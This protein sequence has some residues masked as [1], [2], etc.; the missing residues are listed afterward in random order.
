MSQPSARLHADGKRLSGGN[1]S[2][3][4]GAAAF[5]THFL[6]KHTKLNQD[7]ATK[8]GANLRTEAVLHSKGIKSD[9]QP[10]LPQMQRK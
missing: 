2:C 9:S 1:G 5:A 10:T 6:E 8:K 4:Y 3:A 7:E